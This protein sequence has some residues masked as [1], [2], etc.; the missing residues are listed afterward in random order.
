MP[1]ATFD[2]ADYLLDFLSDEK[3]DQI[4]ALKIKLSEEWQGTR[5]NISQDDFGA[6]FQKHECDSDQRI[7]ALLRA[8]AAKQAMNEQ[9]K[10]ALGEARYADYDRADHPIVDAGGKSTEVFFGGALEQDAIHCYLRL[11]SDK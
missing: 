5:A 10:A 6:A 1:R 4:R 9:V 2:P 11:R 8:E 3:R 7:K